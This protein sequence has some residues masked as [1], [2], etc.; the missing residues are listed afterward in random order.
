MS[1]A[2][3]TLDGQG[4]EAL[5][6]LLDQKVEH[7]LLSLLET[8]AVVSGSSVHVRLRIERNGR[9]PDFI[10]IIIGP[11]TQCADLR[12][13]GIG[14]VARHIAY[15]RHVAQQVVAQSDGGPGF[16]P[17]LLDNDRRGTPRM[18][19]Q[20][21][22]LTVVITP[23]ATVPTAP[24]QLVS[25]QFLQEVELLRVTLCGIVV[26]RCHGTL[27]TALVLIELLGSYL[28][29]HLL[30]E[31]GAGSESCHEADCTEYLKLLCIHN[32][33]FSCD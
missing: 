32:F 23:E 19:A 18:S 5:V 16:A 10:H 15:R 17:S 30:V 14:L 20:H 21:I 26:D 11:G 33:R 2:T 22:F 13:V 31:V 8:D 6:K 4:G 29:V 12:L 24:C 25:R 9:A 1:L 27:Y 7:L 3:T 28:A